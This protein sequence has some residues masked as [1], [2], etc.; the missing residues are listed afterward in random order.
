MGPFKKLMRK[1]KE[2][3]MKQMFYCSKGNS[4]CFSLFLFPF[5]PIRL[6]PVKFLY[7]FPPFPRAFVYIFYR[8]FFCVFVFFSRCVTASVYINIY[9]IY[10][11]FYVFYLITTSRNHHYHTCAV[12]TAS[13]FFFFFLT[14]LHS[15]MYFCFHV[16][17]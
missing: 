9:I 12:V 1:K 7:F 5:D 13:F 4:R 10:F 2:K 16:S 15:N 8:F 11:P 3:K 14:F 17:E 6:H